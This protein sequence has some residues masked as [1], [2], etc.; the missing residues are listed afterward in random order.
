[1]GEKLELRKRKI[2]RDFFPKQCFVWV[3]SLKTRSGLFSSTYVFIIHSFRRQS[4]QQQ[5][6]RFVHV[7]QKSFLLINV[8]HVFV[9]CFI[10]K[11]L[12]SQLRQYRP[13]SGK[14][15]M[16]L[17]QYLNSSV[18]LLLPL[19]FISFFTV[20]VFYNHLISETFLCI[21]S[22]C[23]FSIVSMSL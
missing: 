20:I 9:I 4:S 16:T 23:Q 18:L 13:N 5:C 10:G 1:M 15:K 3:F 22:S 14:W 11:L 12:P 6:L 19:I 7:T 21:L 8:T 2:M 17:I